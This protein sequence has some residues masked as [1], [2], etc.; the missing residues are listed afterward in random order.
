M[1]GHVDLLGPAS[2]VQE[3]LMG[4]PSFDT[5][6][7]SELFSEEKELIG[8]LISMGVSKFEFLE[9]FVGIRPATQD[10]RPFVGSL[11]EKS[12]GIFNGFGSKSVSISPYFA[13]AFIQELRGEK[14]L[15]FEVSIRRYSHLFS[16]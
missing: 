6:D 1:K 12:V 2:K 11:P 7:Y 14:E 8:K 13:K 9:T 4:I 15:D 16:V 10:R 5:P 3:E